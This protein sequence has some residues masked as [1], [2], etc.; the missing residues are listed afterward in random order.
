MMPL[1]RSLPRYTSV[2][3]TLHWIMALGILI[4]AILGLAMVHGEWLPGRLFQLYQLHKSIGITILLLAALRLAWRVVHRPPPL[5]DS[6]PAFERTA[7]AGAHLALYTMLFALPLTG[8]ALVSASVFSIPTVL[9]GLIAWPNLPVLPGLPNKGQV[10]G[11]LK[12]VH[13]YGA[14]V[15]IA[16]VVVHATA[17][18]RHHVILRD[19][20][21]ARMLP[22]LRSRG[23]DA[24]TRNPD[25]QS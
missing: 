18:V 19:N 1:D 17:A 23:L 9:Y 3:I 2:A 22:N 24:S 6:M 7:V 13:A 4:L 11:L 5:P 16:A 20:V 8:W 15:L 12:L 14:Y 25:G 21:L 10:E